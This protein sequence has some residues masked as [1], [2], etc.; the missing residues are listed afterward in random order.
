MNKI[1]K[2]VLSL[3]LAVAFLTANGLANAQNNLQWRPMAM[4]GFNTGDMKF[5]PVS[6]VDMNL[7][8]L[9]WT[10]EIESTRVGPKG[11]YPSFILIGIVNDF[12]SQFTFSIFFAAGA[13]G[14]TP[15][16]NGRGVE[17]MYALCPMRVTQYAGDQVKTLEYPDYCHLIPFPESKPGA[18]NQSQ[19]AYD[20][21]S[22]TVHFRI[23]QNGV[24]IKACD[25]GMKIT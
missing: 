18:L 14:C 11:R 25:R 16:A 15:P 2:L 12:G 19:I 24:H 23:I 5:P 9:A 22:K 6:R 8:R 4:V 17:D 21:K 10:K 13:E 1:F 3:G 20:K 7:A